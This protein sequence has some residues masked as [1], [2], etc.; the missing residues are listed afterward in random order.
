VFASPAALQPGRGRGNYSFSDCALHLTQ[1]YHAYSMTETTKF[2]HANTC[3][4]LL[5]I[6]LTLEKI[7]GDI[8]S[9]PIA[10]LYLRRFG[11]FSRLNT[12]GTYINFSDATRFNH[13]ANSLKIRIEAPFIEVMGMADIVADHWFFS[14]DCT[15]F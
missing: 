14:T 11:N 9:I 15:F 8:S 13:R 10:N 12:R 5:I 6:S 7:K 2:R 1:K 4:N 3:R